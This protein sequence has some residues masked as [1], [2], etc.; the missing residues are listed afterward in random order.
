MQN[1]LRIKA[2][3]LRDSRFIIFQFNARRLSLSLSRLPVSSDDNSRVIR[4][5]RRTCVRDCGISPCAFHVQWNLCL[6]DSSTAMNT[7]P[8]TISPFPRDSSAGFKELAA[9]FRVSFRLKITRKIIN[10]RSPSDVIKAVILG[11]IIAQPSRSHTRLLTRGFQKPW[12]ILDETRHSS[13]DI[14]ILINVILSIFCGFFCKKIFIISFMYETRLNTSENFIYS[15]VY[16]IVR[17]FLKKTL[18]F[19]A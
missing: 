8:T 14:L 18:N 17:L 1:S 9:L 13:Y 16:K 12:I 5:Y 10:G 11:A 2:T 3:I 19:I 4:T 7:L 6:I 15:V